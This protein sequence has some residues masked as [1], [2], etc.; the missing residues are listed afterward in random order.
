[1]VINVQLMFFCFQTVLTNEYQQNWLRPL[2]YSFRFVTH[3]PIGPLT[4]LDTTNVCS[5]CDAFNVIINMKHSRA[6]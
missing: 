2:I 1:L 4:L 5:W 6:Q 3:R